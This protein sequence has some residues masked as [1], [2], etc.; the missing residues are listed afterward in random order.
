MAGQSSNITLK[1]RK[2]LKEYEIS[3]QFI[4]TRETLKKELI[5]ALER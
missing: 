5:E 3:K 2:I 4:A 1:A